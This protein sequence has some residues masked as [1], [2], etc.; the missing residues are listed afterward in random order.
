MAV[1]VSIECCIAISD[2]GRRSATAPR[3]DPN[4]ATLACLAA[5]LLCL[6]SAPAWA[7]CESLY[8]RQL[9]EWS[10]STFSEGRYTICYAPEYTEDT[11]VAAE[12]IDNAFRI[13]LDKYGVVPPVQRR[14]HTLTIT[15]FMV[16]RPTSRA[17]SSTATVICCQDSV[18]LEIHIMTPSSR[19]YGRPVDDFIKTLTHEMMNTLHYEAR[20]PP[21]LSPPL[22]IREGLAEYEG[23]YNTTPG[24][25]AKV[26][27]LIDY[28]YENKRDSI[29]YG[30]TLL[31]DVAQIMSTDRYYGS[32]VVLIFLADQ[33][34]EDLH[35]QLFEEPL[36]E[37]LH[38]RYG[39]TA[40][41]AFEDLRVWLYRKH[42][43]I[44]DRPAG[45]DYTPNMACTGRYWY[46]N[47][48]IS[49]EVRIL[50]NDRRP[51]NHE[52]FQQQYRR[53]ASRPWTTKSSLALVLGN[54]SG[55]STPLFT[56]VSSPPFQWRARSC[57]RQR[58]TDNVCSNWSNI[59]N[60]TAASCARSR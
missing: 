38:E 49:F 47:S 15:I 40:L 7:A 20:E 9:N 29:L 37:L 24:N 44:D 48:G 11:F 28:V 21:N 18:S 26:D 31:D 6:F 13:A 36:S 22:W 41:Q 35:A 16:P 33:F 17:N 42:Q 2:C 50:N 34:G 12:W 58:Q 3:M 27:W 46:T 51:A 53:D 52:V 14:G 59:I 56:S 55:F 5:C 23:Y 8:D 57:P 43:A 4:V 1:Q 30:R 45:A 10:W 60:W 39:T 19:D 32:T 25:R 54:T